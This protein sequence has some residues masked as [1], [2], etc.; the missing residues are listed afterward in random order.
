M[1]RASARP[2]GLPN[3]DVLS[4]GEVVVALA[5]RERVDRITLAGSEEPGR[6]DC[7]AFLRVGPLLLSGGSHRYS[8]MRGLA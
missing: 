7:Q 1:Q 2:A 6:R 3:P 8:R 4:T 5:L